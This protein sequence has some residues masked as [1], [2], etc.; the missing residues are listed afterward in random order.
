MVTIFLREGVS[1]CAL[2]HQ[3][4]LQQSCY[5]RAFQE[6]YDGSHQQLLFIPHFIQKVPQNVLRNEH[7]LLEIRQRV[8]Q[9]CGYC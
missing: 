1:I 4:Q 2:V 8:L 7:Q 3:A 5:Q 6:P 9:L